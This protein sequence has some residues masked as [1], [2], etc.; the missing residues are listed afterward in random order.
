MTDQTVLRVC[1]I[2]GAFVTAGYVLRRVR[3]ARVQI[4]DTIYWLALSAVLLL[5]AVFPGIAYWVSDLLGFVSPINCVFLVII[6]LLL[7]RQFVLSIRVSQL[8]SRLRILTE[9]IA[10]NQQRQEQDKQKSPD[11][12]MDL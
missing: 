11:D 1:L 5:V 12:K 7:A 3:Q 9:R 6:F 2:L 10:L 8:D 4:E